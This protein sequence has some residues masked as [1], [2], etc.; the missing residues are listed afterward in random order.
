MRKIMFSILL[1]LIISVF[2]PSKQIKAYYGGDGFYGDEIDNYEIIDT[3]MV[4]TKGSRIPMWIGGTDTYEYYTYYLYS[5]LRI[6]TVKLANDGFTPIINNK[7]TASFAEIYEIRKDFQTSTTLSWEAC[8]NASLNIALIN[9]QSW[10]YRYTQGE[11][12]EFTRNNYNNTYGTAALISLEMKIVERKVLQ[13]VEYGGIGGNS[14]V[15][16]TV[17]APTVTEYY[18][19][20]DYDLLPIEVSDIDLL[21][22]NYTLV[23]GVYKPKFY[24]NQ[25]YSY[26]QDYYNALTSTIRNSYYCK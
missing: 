14:E 8:E 15:G 18:F 19:V 12:F 10:I 23:N 7:I 6:N 13:E 22:G 1:I 26:N 20:V 4:Y 24:I 16:R 25:I 5:K 3:K 2:M 9:R 21:S 11:E 17:Y